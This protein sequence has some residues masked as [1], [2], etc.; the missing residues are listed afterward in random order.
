[1]EVLAGSIIKAGEKLAVPTP[2]NRFL[3][4]QLRAIEKMNGIG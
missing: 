2:V 3:F 4:N 1:V